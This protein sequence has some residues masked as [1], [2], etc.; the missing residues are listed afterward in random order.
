MEERVSFGQD[1]AW[2]VEAIAFDVCA[3]L[4]GLLPIEATSA[5]GGWF[6]RT[7]GPLT[8]QQ[9][10]IRTNLSIAFP[11]KDEAWIRTAVRGVWDNVGRSFIELPFGRRIIDDPKRIEIVGLDRLHRIRDSGGPA[12]FVSGHMGNWEVMAPTMLREGLDLMI[13]YRGA[14]NPYV[15]QRIRDARARIGV[16]RFARK[17]AGNMRRLLTALN[18]GVSLALLTDQR[19]EE[20]QPTPFFGKLAHTTPGAV[21]LALKKRV[22]LVPVSIQRLPGVRFRFVVHDPMP[23][24]DTGSEE[25]DVRQMMTQMNATLE[26]DIRLAPAQYFWVHRRWPK[27]TYEKA[28]A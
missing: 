13:G 2:R 3:G 21:R 18:Q 19:T 4:L 14:N 28:A 5:F 1:F 9:H 23:W 20:G 11:D 15:D 6:L 10:I 26:A 25:G 16:Q 24:P 27:P 7:F 8:R 22:P 12:I 17:D